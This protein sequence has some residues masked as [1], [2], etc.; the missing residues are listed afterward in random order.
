[1]ITFI[2]IIGVVFAFITLISS[3]KVINQGEK[4]V[5]LRLGKFK[6]VA[7]PG[8]NLILPYI[9]TMIKVDVRERVINVEPQKVIT[10]DNVTVTVDAVIYYKVVDPVKAEFEVE[11]FDTAATTLAQTNLRNVVGD[12]SL[13]ETLTARD[14]IN[15]NLRDVLDEVTHNWGVKVTR[16]E[17][18]KIDPPAEIT[19]AM[20]LQM[21]A[22][23]EKRASILQSEGIKQS[24]ILEA[25][26]RKSAEILRAEGDAQ[27]KILRANA[28][29]TAI[30]KL[31]EAANK[32]FDEKAQ[33]WK[34]L[35]VA[36]VV[37]ANNAKFVIP[38]SSDIV[39]VLNLEGDKSDVIPMKRK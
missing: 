13:D 23:R 7:E 9:E 14:I 22:E 1:M 5:V 30:Q 34:K 26:G 25:D 20:S 4:A 39:N 31:A 29:A 10:K 8:L 12:K 33:I 27:A 36:S 21:K 35:E 32:Y 11:D 19:E 6:A 28:E 24:Q 15:T 3:V 37:L 16:V 38:T 18:Q 17:V 2:F